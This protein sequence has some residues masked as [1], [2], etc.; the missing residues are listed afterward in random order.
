MTGERTL[1]GLGLTGFWD[2][3]DDTW[4][5]T[6]D[7]NLLRLSA[8][9]SSFK[10]LSRLDALPAGTDGDV[11]IIAAGESTGFD[12]FSIAVKDDGAWVV[13]PPAV[14]QRAFVEDEGAWYFFNGSEWEASGEGGA[15]IEVISTSTHT[16]T[17]DNIGKMSRCTH[18]SGCTITLEGGF[19][20]NQE[21]HFVQVDADPITFVADTGVTL[22]YAA[23]RDPISAEV[24]AVVTAKY[25]ATD[26]WL[27]FGHLAEA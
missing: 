26:T 6:M 13:F 2:L 10:A 12:E 25:I 17:I 18:T 3:G 4:K 5:D 23:S 8:A 19:R 24:G 22:E 16:I 20:V 15:K 21:A 7:L 9:G 11:Y 14:G 1:P 27:L